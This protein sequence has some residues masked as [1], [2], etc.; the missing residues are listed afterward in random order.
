MQDRLSLFVGQF[1]GGH[2]CGVVHTADNERSVRIAFKEINND[3]MT[4]ARPVGSTPIQT[5]L[6]LRYA[7]PARTPRSSPFMRMR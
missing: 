7:N 5:G 4:N 3:L 1:V 6:I 2:F